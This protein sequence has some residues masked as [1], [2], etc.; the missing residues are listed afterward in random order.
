MPSSTTPVQVQERKEAAL[1]GWVTALAQTRIPVTGVAALFAATEM[2]VAGEDFGELTFRL[3]PGKS[4]ARMVIVEYTN[5]AA[6]EH[7]DAPRLPR[8]TGSSD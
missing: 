3:S 1:G 6:V 4:G 8:Q 2:L 5:A 7:R